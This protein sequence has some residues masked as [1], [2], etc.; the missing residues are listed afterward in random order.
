MRQRHERFHRHQLQQALL[1]LALSD[2]LR[3]SL[4]MKNTVSHRLEYLQQLITTYTELITRSG[5]AIYSAPPPIPASTAMNPLVLP[6]TTTCKYSNPFHFCGFVDFVL[7]IK[8]KF[9]QASKKKSNFHQYETKCLKI[10][11][12]LFNFWMKKL[13]RNYPR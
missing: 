4:C 9:N 1:F 13:D 6:I 10:L 11:I 3:L 12:T 5:I 7:K 2:S 8:P